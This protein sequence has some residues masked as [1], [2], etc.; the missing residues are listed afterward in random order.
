MKFDV[1]IGNPPY[2]EVTAKKKINGQQPVHNIFQHFQEL[3]DELNVDYSSLIYPGRRWIHQSG[4]G[5][6]KFGYNLINDKH[7]SKLIYFANA[8]DVF[9]EVGIADGI[10]IVFKDYHKNSSKFEYEYISKDKTI[11]KDILNSPGKELLVLN[12]KERSISQKI[13]KFIK[14]HHLKTIHDS[15]VLKSRLFKIESNFVEKNPDKVRLLTPDSKID[16]SKEIKLFTND[17]AGKTG[18]ATWFIANKNLITEHPQL[19]DKWKVIVSTAN[20][21][22]QKRD[23]KIQI[24][25]NHSAFGRSRVALK[26]FDTKKEAQNF[27]K[28]TKCTVIRFAFLLTD[29]ALTSVGKEVPDIL[30]Y[31]DENPFLNFSKDIDQQ[32]SRLLGLT[33]K[34]EEYMKA[35]ITNVRK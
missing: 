8:N 4:K 31:Q 26:A 1:V 13:N 14:A 19:I 7:L 22:G 27:L 18:R 28:Y 16:Y 23:N 33:D 9:P 30:N 11:S 34:E 3:A 5:L 2:Q 20:A 21:G 32:F 10:S 12:P 29:E 15:P 6:K 25:D 17:K 35:R 24:V